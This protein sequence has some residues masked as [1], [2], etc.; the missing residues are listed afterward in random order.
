VKAATWPRP[1]PLAERMLV[2]DARDAAFHDATIAGLVAETRAGD[3][4]VVNDAATVPAS[5][6]GRT[7]GGAA[8]EIRLAARR[9]GGA[10]QAIAFGAGDWRTRTEDRPPPPP[11]AEGDPI[12]FGAELRARVTAVSSRRLVEIAFDRDG[13]ALWSSLYALGK[14]VQYA[15][16]ERPLAL[17][18]VQTAYAGR[19]WASELCSAGRPLTW[20]LLE[21]LRGRGVIVTWLTH[22]AGLSSTGD[23]ALDLRLPLPEAFDIPP[24]TAHRIK[25]AKADRRRVI[26][27]GTS[28]VRA[29]EGCVAQHRGSVVAGEGETDLVLSPSYR[30]QIVDGLLTG[31]HDRSASHFALLGAFA[32]PALLDRAYGHAERAG[33]LCHE[34]GDSGLLLGAAA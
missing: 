1:N 29:L 3:V 6:H 9:K 28:V 8:I 32:P 20:S 26:A 30:R 18:H 2:I 11:L 17:W 14:P 12:V 15:Y 24:E 27:V 31:M 13:A 7:A 23:A 21:V 5:L 25:H 19:P 34:F 4:L 16:T 33:Y 22:A 10:W